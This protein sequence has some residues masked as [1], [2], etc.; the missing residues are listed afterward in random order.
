LATSTLQKQNSLLFVPR[1]TR[2]APYPIQSID[3]DIPGVVASFN[4]CLVPA[5]KAAKHDCKDDINIERFCQAFYDLL[6]VLRLLGTAFYFVEKDIVQKLEAIA[7]NKQK[8]PEGDHKKN[9]IDFIHWEKETNPNIRKDKHS[10][11]RHALRLMRA[12]HFI[13]VRTLDPILCLIPQFGPPP[14]QKKTDQFSYRMM[15][16]VLNGSN[17]QLFLDKLNEPGVEPKPAAKDAYA[18]SLHQY[19][20][21]SVRTAVSVAFYTLPYRK[22]FLK[23]LHMDPAASGLFLDFVTVTTKIR[24][25]LNLYYDAND[26]QNLP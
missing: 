5:R 11:A 3:K 2:P 20:P 18:V 7:E 15:K 10:T 16:T 19:H 1:L 24:D 4:S 17:D 9:L 22:S 8:S 26:W 23:D 14:P 25:R 21:W 6:P 13:S 12:L